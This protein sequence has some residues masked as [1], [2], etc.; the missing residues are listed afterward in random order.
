LSDKA[1]A[2]FLDRDGVIN[3]ERGYVHTPDQFV[4]IPRVV[5][6]I[7]RLRSAGFKVVVVTNQSGVARGFFNIA[8]VDRLHLHLQ[9]LL[10]AEGQ[11]VDKIY[12]CPHHCEGT[13]TA[14]SVKCDCRKPM[15]G[16]LLRAALELNL[17]LRL[18][19][20]IG[21]KLSD[22]QAGRRAGVKKVFLVS[23]GHPLSVEAISYADHVAHDTYEAVSVILGKESYS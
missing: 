13:I 12:Y 6:A 18:C 23:T 7:R 1:K 10:A 14:Y 19:Y 8:A 3:E 16:L 2:V 4:L 5:D 15:P 17:D 22:I 11:Q 20:L 21:D 9:S